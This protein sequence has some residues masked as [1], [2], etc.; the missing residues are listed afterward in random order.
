MKCEYGYTRIA[1]PSERG[2]YAQGIYF[3]E[4]REN[5]NHVLTKRMV[6]NH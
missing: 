2:N 3:V 5:N 4:I 1:N 6:I